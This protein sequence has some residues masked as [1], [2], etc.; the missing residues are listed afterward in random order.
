MRLQI[1][2]GMPKDLETLK[3]IWSTLANY[4]NNM[5]DASSND[6]TKPAGSSWAVRS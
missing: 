3:N 4:H 1:H 2:Q 5:D 6:S